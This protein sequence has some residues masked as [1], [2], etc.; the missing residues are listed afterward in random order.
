MLANVDLGSSHSDVWGWSDGTTYVA[1]IGHFGGT[2]FFDVTNPASP[3]L[4]A[5]IPG[6][7][8][9]WR[10][11]KTYQD[12]AYIVTEGFGTGEGL[13]IVEGVLRKLV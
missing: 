6:P 4:I 8:S 3:S 11:I 1:I 5:N 13:Q 9:S 7:G 2:R 12:H 10:D